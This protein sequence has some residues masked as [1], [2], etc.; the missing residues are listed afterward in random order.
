MEIRPGPVVPWRQVLAILQERLDNGTYPP[1]SRLP[2][3]VDLSHE[4]GV[5]LTTVRKALDS[6]KADGRLVTNPT[7][8][9]VSGSSSG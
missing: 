7:G 5:A 4:F 6:L 1:G 2:S 9:Y 3:I 8:T